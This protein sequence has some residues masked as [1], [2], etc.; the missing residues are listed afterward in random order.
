MLPAIDVYLVALVLISAL[1]HAAWNAV[2]KLGSDRLLA[3]VTVKLPTTVVAAA[4]LLVVEAPA[5][6]SWPYLIA[7]TVVSSGYFYFLVKA[8]HAGD[9]SVAY[10]VARGIA[11]VAVLALSVLLLGELPGAAGVA[12]VMIISLGILWLCFRREAPREYT[13]NLLWACGVGLTIAGYTILDGVGGRLSGSPV[14]YAAVL[15]IMTAI[16]LLVVAFARRGPVVVA[17]VRRDWLKG[18]TGGTM[19]FAA[20]AI[21]IYAMTLAP[22][23]VIAALRETGVIFAAAI[24]TILFREGFGMRRVAAACMVAAGIAVLVLSR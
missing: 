21:V 24:G 4:T 11:P 17:V 15:N 2:V 22:M 20:Y 5:P 9:L 6:A 18:L 19:M 8:Y 16:P 12:G 7:S 10:P 3:L 14:G 23:A 1:L 13:V